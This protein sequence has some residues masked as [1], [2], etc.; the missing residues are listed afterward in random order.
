MSNSVNISLAA[1]KQDSFWFDGHIDEEFLL[2]LMRIC[3]TKHICI[4]KA[5]Y[6]TKV[7][8]EYEVDILVMGDLNLALL[9]AHTVVKMD[10]KESFL[11]SEE[12]VSWS[13]H[14]KN[15]LFRADETYFLDSS[16][17]DIELRIYNNRVLWSNVNAVDV[18]EVLFNFFVEA[19]RLCM[20]EILCLEAW[21]T[22]KVMFFAWDEVRGYMELEFVSCFTFWNAII[23]EFMDA[24]VMLLGLI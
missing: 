24:L 19:N 10:V 21:E 15:C 5:T 6:F 22:T 3:S 23:K 8:V 20:E 16:L 9:I 2:S 12:E 11:I 4:N 13:I 1:I 18:M 14:N 7:V 17:I